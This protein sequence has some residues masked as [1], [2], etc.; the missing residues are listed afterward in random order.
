MAKRLLA[1]YMVAIGIT[2]AVNFVLTPV[3][4]DG[5]SQYP[6]WEILNW[7]MVAAALVTLVVGFRRRRDPDH[8]D[9]SAVEYLRGS[10]AYYGAIVLTMLM[11]WEWY[12]TLNPSSETGDA[13]TAHLIYFPIVNALFVILALASGRYLWNEAGGS[14]G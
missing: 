9:V 14:S 5:T 3:Y 11:L 13:V 8:A 4:H 10:F 7:F 6:I 2:V 1:F 12:W